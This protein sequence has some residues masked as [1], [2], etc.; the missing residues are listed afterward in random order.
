[1]LAI[2]ALYPA[3]VA[4]RTSMRRLY[5]DLEEFRGHLLDGIREDA[6]ERAHEFA[7]PNSEGEEDDD[8]PE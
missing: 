3:S 5:L 2:W 6:V 7:C 1:M 8:Y 4:F